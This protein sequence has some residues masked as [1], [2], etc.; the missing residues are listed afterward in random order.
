MPNVMPDIGDAPQEQQP[1]SQRGSPALAI[2]TGAVD[3]TDFASL[4]APYVS[5]SQPDGA[6]STKGTLSSAGVAVLVVDDHDDMVEALVMLIKQ[7]G[8]DLRAATSATQALEML[9]TFKA[10][11]V[12]LDQHAGC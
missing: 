11:L 5:V 10:T 6:G 3:G 4:Y 12:L 9:K 7:Y 2:S 8:C 1:A